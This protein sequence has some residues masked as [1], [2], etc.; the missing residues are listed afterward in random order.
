ML[1]MRTTIDMR[2]IG[3]GLVA[4][5]A[6]GHACAQTGPAVAAK[7]VV[8]PQVASG[9]IRQIQARRDDLFKAMLARP[10]D[11]DAAFEYAALSV[12][13]GDLEAAIGTLERM[14]IFSPGLPRLQ[15]ELGL[16]YYRL[17]AFETAR[18]YFESAVSGSGVPPEVRAKVDQYLAGIDSAVETTRFAGQVRAGIRYQ[19]NA[20]R[21]P[22]DGTI[23][24]NGLPFLLDGNSRGSSDGNVYGAGIFHLSQNLAS[25]GDTLEIDLLTYGSKQFE[26]D[27]LDVALAELTIGPA[28]DMG[29]F[30]IDDA[31]LGVYGIASLVAVDGAFYSSAVGAGARYVVQPAPGSSFTTALEYRYRG[32]RDSDGAPT[33]SDRDGDEVRAYAAA[34]VVVAPDMALSGSAYIQRVSADRDY[35]AYTE[36]GFSAGPR[37]SFA[38]PFGDDRGAWTASLNAGALFRDYDDPDPLIDL[39][40]DEHDWEAFVGGGLTVP[41]MDR[42]AL[43]GETEY[44]HVDS[45]YSTRNHDNVSVTLSVARSF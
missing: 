17:S 16:L 33:A 32:Y 39:T 25:Q 30:G 42:V 36:G 44:R 7:S 12:Q 20:N 3:L 14:L 37:Y 6:A 5:L 28:F 4:V 40:Q 41:I 22:T 26:R 11:L 45:N 31:A 1:G 27:E 2:A 9:D 43:L 13:A 23:M 35:L 29:R 34:A 24:L 15:L 38:S 8:Q 18:G 10:D 19:S 21:A